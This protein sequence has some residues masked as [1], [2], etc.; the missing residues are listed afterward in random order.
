MNAARTGRSYG[1]KVTEVGLPRSVFG[2][3][4]RIRTQISADSGGDG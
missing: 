3:G 2:P 1:T 4:S